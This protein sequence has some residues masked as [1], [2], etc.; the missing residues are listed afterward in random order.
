MSNLFLSYLSPTPIYILPSG[1][2][3]LVPGWAILS[4][5]GSTRGTGTHPAPG[6]CSGRAVQGSLW[7]GGTRAVLYELFIFNKQTVQNVSIVS[8]PRNCL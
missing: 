3:G 7:D 5:G 8:K 2:L 6:T 1:Y 4:L